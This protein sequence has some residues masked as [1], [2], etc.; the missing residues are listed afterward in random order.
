M[1]KLR[2][3]AIRLYLSFQ[4]SESLMP[5][6]PPSVSP[7]F[8]VAVAIIVQPLFWWLS[9]PGPQLRDVY[10]FDAAILSCI[11]SLGLLFAIPAAVALFQGTACLGCQGTGF[12]I[13]CCQFRPPTVA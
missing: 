3:F 2:S 8:Y 9:M 7:W 6:R 11:W 5:S 4:K 13:E 1:N 12:K 10:Q